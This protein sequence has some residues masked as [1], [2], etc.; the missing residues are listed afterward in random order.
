MLHVTTVHVAEGS[1]T[2]SHSFTPP[3]HLWDA[4]GMTYTTTTTGKA[5]AAAQKEKKVQWETKN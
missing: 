1:Y 4:K 3:A 2:A 5:K